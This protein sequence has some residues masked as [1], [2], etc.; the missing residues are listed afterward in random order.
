MTFSVTT[1]V[2]CSTEQWSQTFYEAHLAYWL[3]SGPSPTGG[4]WCPAPH[5]KYITPFNVWPPVC[6]IHPFSDTLRHSEKRLFYWNWG[7]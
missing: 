5:L 3:T 7:T 1:N 6:C 2:K 4:Q